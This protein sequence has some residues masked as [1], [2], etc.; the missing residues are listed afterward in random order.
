MTV[1]TTT[2]GEHR[3]LKITRTDYVG[4]RQPAFHLELEYVD[5]DGKSFGL[6]AATIPIYVFEGSIN[7]NALNAFPL[8]FHSKEDTVKKALIERGRKFE[9]YRGRHNMEYKGISLGEVVRCRRVQ[10]NVC[11]PIGT[12]QQL[13]R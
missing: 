2:Y 12:P 5:Y 7:I 9:G 8:D 10:Y 6:A 3:A 1:F 11:S 4:G 13:L